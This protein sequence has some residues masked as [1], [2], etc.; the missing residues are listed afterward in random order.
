MATAPTLNDIGLKVCRRFFYKFF[1][2]ELKQKYILKTI[3][4]KYFVLKHY[5]VRKGKC[6][7][8]VNAF[9][10]AISN[11]SFCKQEQILFI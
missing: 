6:D 4:K 7:L 1:F 2:Q 3:K 11:N 5:S 9:S 10:W 8:V